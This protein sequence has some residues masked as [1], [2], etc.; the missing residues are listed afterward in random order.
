MH[1]PAGTPAIRSRAALLL[2]LAAAIVTILVWRPWA[3]TN[4]AKRPGRWHDFPG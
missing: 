3:P 1:E 4:F 2:V